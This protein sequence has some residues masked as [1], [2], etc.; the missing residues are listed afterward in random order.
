MCVPATNNDTQHV[1]AG[2]QRGLA[3]LQL[4][5]DYPEGLRFSDIQQQLAFSKTACTRVLH[6]LK[7]LDFI[8]HSDIDHRYRSGPACQQ[9]APA[10]SPQLALLNASQTAMQELAQMGQWSVALI[11][12]TGE[13]AIGLS[14]IIVDKQCPLQEP[15]HIT[16][17]IVDNPYHVFFLSQ[18]QWRR[19]YLDKAAEIADGLN[20]AW[21][22]QERKRLKQHG[23][24]VA[25]NGGRTRIA[26]PIYRGKHCMGAI[27]LGSSS[28]NK[29]FLNA[30]RKLNLAS[31]QILGK[32]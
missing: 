7:G 15:G 9:L 12:W 13:Q 29:R 4:L 19:M 17:G 23:Y 5:A 30:G 28:T 24:T 11:Y 6:H 21:Y 3:V 8:T 16:R 2:L 14:R 1:P 22:E 26:A 18:R 32:I 31:R 20:H 10:F 25:T 27:L